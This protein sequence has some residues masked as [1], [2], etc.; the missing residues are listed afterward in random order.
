MKIIVKKEIG[1]TE[2]TFEVEHE[3]DIEALH[4]A[5]I[6]GNPR[7]R[8]NQCNNSG[9]DNFRLDSNKSQ[10]FTFVN[11]ICRKCGAKSK[12]GLYKDGGYFWHE[13]EKYIKEGRGTQI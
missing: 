12:L 2:Y 11:I 13:F 9:A 6:F 5:A 3:K 7:L 10:G 1:G 4:R 8:C